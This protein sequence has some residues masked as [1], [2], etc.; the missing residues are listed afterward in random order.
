MSGRSDIKKQLRFLVHD[1]KSLA[2]KIFDFSVQALVLIS[3]ISFTVETLPG[4]S[5]EAKSWLHKIEIVTVAIF[6]LEYLLRLYVEDKKLKFIFSFFGLVDFLAILPFYLSIGIDLRSI[7]A[8][9][10]VRLVR[11]F[12][13]MRYS[14]ALRIY[15]DAF[16]Q[17]K[18]ELVVFLFMTLFLLYFSAV[19]IYY[20]E[21][22]AQPDKFQSIF[23]SLW[24]ALAT[25]TTVGYGDI[26]PITVG[27]KIF[28]FFM[29]MIGLGIVA[30]PAGLIS[31]ALVEVNRKANDK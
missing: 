1:H 10:M 22:P 23:H 28:T 24:W 3:I 29:L 9:R 6:S 15:A 7:R 16:Y 25:L 18:E 17:I 26:Y 31:A 4:L 30:V 20:F 11:L 2:G 27:G 12:K 14:K 21:H 8:V 5:P 13:L 19:G